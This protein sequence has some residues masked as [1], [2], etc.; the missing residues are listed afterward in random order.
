MNIILIII[1]LIIVFILIWALMGDRT[2][3]PEE[4]EGDSRQQEVTL[5]RRAS[6]KKIEREYPD[7]RTPRRRKS[8]LAT[9]SPSE[10]DEAAVPFNLPYPAEEIIPDTSQFRIYRRTLLNSEVY[11]GK[12]DYATAISLYEGVKSRIRDVETRE[13]I[14]AN[15]EYLTQYKKRK[16]N[17][18]RKKEEKAKRGMLGEQSQPGGEIRIMLGGSFPE[19]INI[20]S[21]PETIHIGVI[22]PTKNLNIEALEKTIT[23]N[24][25][26]DLADI[27]SD[28]DRIK[29]MPPA[30]A[31]AAQAKLIEALAGVKAGLDKIEATGGTLSQKDI[32]FIKEGKRRYF[33]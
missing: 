15:I 5:R 1:L 20:D 29:G 26:K 14:D 12:G 21:L 7:E 24:L 6:D 22:D 16:E 28:I 27:R 9:E 13:K 32:D 19:S 4:T 2:S 31:A 8:D 17:E 10:A 33:F 3:V 11:A 25:R 18:A 23:Q 30:E